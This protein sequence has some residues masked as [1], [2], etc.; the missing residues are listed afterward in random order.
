MKV[1]LGMQHLATS[2]QAAMQAATTDKK[3]AAL[4]GVCLQTVGGE[5]QVVATDGTWIARISRPVEDADPDFKLRVP[6]EHCR[7][8]LALIGNEE[9]EAVVSRDATLARFALHNVGT[10]DLRFGFAE[11]PF[12]STERCW[13]TGPFSPLEQIGLN[14]KLMAKLA[15]TF[16]IASGT[17]PA[18]A[19]AF[20][21]A[22][23]PVVVT[24][25]VAPHCTALLMPCALRDEEES[26]DRQVKLFEK[27]G[28]GKGKG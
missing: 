2:V 19:F 13:P 1:E 8:L 15:K 14:P 5:L 21:G 10:L 6:L 26:P 18:L 9:G 20:R 22:T 25:E 17:Q 27:D 11:V 4:H 16:E 28:P 23:A 24:C 12:P 7:K 3:N